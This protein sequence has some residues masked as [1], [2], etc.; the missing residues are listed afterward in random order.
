MDFFIAFFIL[1]YLQTK[2]D[3]P[4]INLMLFIFTVFGLPYLFYC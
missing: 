3:E 4:A 1:L 2:V